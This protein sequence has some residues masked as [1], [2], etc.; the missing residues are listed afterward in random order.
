MKARPPKRSFNLLEAASTLGLYGAGLSLLLMVLLVCTEVVLRRTAGISTGVSDEWS[1]FL[2]VFIVFLG[3]GYTARVDG[4]V[5]LEFGLA[6]HR[7]AQL[8]QQLLALVVVAVL[9]YWMFR[10]IEFSYSFGIRSRFASRTPLFL[11]QLAMLVGSVILALQILAALVGRLGRSVQ[12][13]KGSQPP[14]LDDH[15]EEST[16]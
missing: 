1:G 13:R 11:P 12:P 10:E 5:R 9:G 14:P 8:V 3:L 15:Q 6:R 4:F 2:L 7:A 16:R